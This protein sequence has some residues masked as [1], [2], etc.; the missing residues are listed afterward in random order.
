MRTS[1]EKCWGTTHVVRD[2]TVL[3]TRPCIYP[4]MVQTIPLLLIL[5][6]PEEWKAESTELADYVPRWFTCPKTVTHP[7]T[8]R[9]RLWLTLSIRPTLLTNTACHRSKYPRNS[10]KI[11]NYCATLNLT[12]MTCLSVTIRALAS[13]PGWPP[14]ITEK[15]YKAETN[16]FSLKKLPRWMQ[17]LNAVIKVSE[18]QRSKHSTT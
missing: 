1:S 17:M 14:A 18:I 15:F 4:R 9:A 8:N 7:S 2:L 5:P 6:T 3:P 13:D 11:T 16:I 12:N 10:Q